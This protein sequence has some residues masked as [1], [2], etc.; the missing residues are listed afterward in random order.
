MGPKPFWEKVAEWIAYKLP[1]NIV[2]ECIFRAQGMVML[3]RKDPYT[4]VTSGEMADEIWR[5]QGRGR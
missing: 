2:R 1:L 4:D 5:L 3:R